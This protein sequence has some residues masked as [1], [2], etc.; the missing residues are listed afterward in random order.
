MPRG[1]RATAQVARRDRVLATTSV[2]SGAGR[3]ERRAFR[4]AVAAHLAE[5]DL[6]RIGQPRRFRFQ[7]G[8]REEAR[9]H[10]ERV[11]DRVHRRLVGLEV[12]RGDA[13][14]GTLGEPGV[15]KRRARQSDQL[16]RT[17]QPRSQPTPSASTGGWR[18]SVDAARSLTPPSAGGAG[19][20]RH[21]EN[22]S[23]HGRGIG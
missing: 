23:P 9:R 2:A 22:S 14:D 18:T 1:A 4:D 17:R 3:G 11:G 7:L 8:R 21:R 10:A 15:A 16:A 5:H 13:G 20:V 19:V 6:G 12:D